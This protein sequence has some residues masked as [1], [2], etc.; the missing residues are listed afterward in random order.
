MTMI[1]RIIDG[2]NVHAY[3]DMMRT[4]RL[5]SFGLG[6]VKGMLEID[7]MQLR[8]LRCFSIWLC[9]IANAHTQSKNTNINEQR[10]TSC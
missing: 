6:T 10:N 9:G 2:H 5:M 7:S 4:I 8:T 3:P 1:G